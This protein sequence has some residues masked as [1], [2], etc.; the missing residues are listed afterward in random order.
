MKGNSSNTALLPLLLQTIRAEGAADHH[1]TPRCLEPA[2]G[3]CVFAP[4]RQAVCSSVVLRQLFGSA[5]CAPCLRFLCALFALSVLEQGGTYR[6]ALQR[7]LASKDSPDCHE[8]SATL[9]NS[10]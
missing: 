5:L 8:T 9:Y 6:E 3:P 4:F 10:F 1:N 2:D 7:R